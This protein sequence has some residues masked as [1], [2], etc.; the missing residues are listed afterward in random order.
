MIGYTYTEN[1]SDED[2]QNDMLRLLAL[3]EIKKI[4]KEDPDITP[5]EIITT[6]KN[7]SL[8]DDYQLNYQV[9]DK[10]TMENCEKYSD[11]NIY[12]SPIADYSP[13]INDDTINVFIKALQNNTDFTYD[14]KFQVPNFNTIKS[15]NF[16][17]SVKN[18]QIHFDWNAGENNFII[19]H[20]HFIA[21]SKGKIIE[22]AE[23]EYTVIFPSYNENVLYNTE[24]TSIRFKDYTTVDEEEGINVD[25]RTLVGSL[26]EH[27]TLIAEYCDFNINYPSYMDVFNDSYILRDCKSKL[28]STKSS[29]RASLLDLDIDENTEAPQLSLYGGFETLLIKNKSEDI[30]STYDSFKIHEPNRGMSGEAIFTTPLKDSIKTALNKEA[31]NG[32]VFFS[33]ENVATLPLIK[34]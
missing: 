8:P 25:E 19:P 4:T 3:R 9:F 34:I 33:M 11:G 28:I 10:K 14:V 31:F 7:T 32:N 15:T 1:K 22:T 27:R 24:E 20:R 12:G 6:L 23:D 21:V 29:A 2:F 18:K 16:I 17:G 30:N 26:D 13:I 5:D